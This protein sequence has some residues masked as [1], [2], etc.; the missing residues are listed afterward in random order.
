M[1]LVKFL[2]MA[3][4]F[5]KIFRS[6]CMVSEILNTTKCLIGQKHSFYSP[7]AV[8]RSEACPLGMQAA[9]GSIPTSGT[10]IRGKMSTAILPP[11]LIQEEQSPSISHITGERMCTKYW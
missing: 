9:P 11:P 8:A 5:D 6:E 7:G 2:N 1:S 3:Y 4:S 10:I